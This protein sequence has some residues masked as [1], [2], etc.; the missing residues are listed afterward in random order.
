MNFG[1]YTAT[2]QLTINN[3]DY[4]S[5]LTFASNMSS[6]I[7]DSSKFTFTNGGVAS[8]SWN[9]STF[10]ITAIP[11]TST[12]VAALGLLA[13]CALPLARRHV[14]RATRRH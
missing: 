3:F 13:L 8:S 1:S 7:N 14:A 12:Y 11:E 9:G 6:S 5:T 2:E 4:G 10:T